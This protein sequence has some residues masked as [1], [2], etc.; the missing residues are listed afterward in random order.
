LEGRERWEFVGSRACAVWFY[1]NV[2]GNFNLTPGKER[3]EGGTDEFIGTENPAEIERK[4]NNNSAFK[5]FGFG[6]RGR[7]A[8]RRLKPVPDNVLFTQQDREE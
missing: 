7:A 1:G 4:E 6:R 5:G 2:F 8:K 3:M